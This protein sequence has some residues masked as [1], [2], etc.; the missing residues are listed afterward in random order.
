MKKFLLV[1]ISFLV[2]S[3]TIKLVLHARR[4]EIGI[5]KY[6]GATDSFIKLPFVIEGIIV[7]IVG[8]VISWEITI[9]SYALIE[10]WI[11]NKFMT[12]QLLPMNLEIL[13]INLVIGVLVG[14]FS[15]MMSI[16]KYLKV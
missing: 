4:K 2:I 8:A 1:G 12:V 9:S 5:M 3:N 11:K 15:S 7:G 14:I 6:I 10:A 13:N 16:K